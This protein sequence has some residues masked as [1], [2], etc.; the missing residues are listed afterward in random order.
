MIVM[1][2]ALLDRAHVADPAHS[3]RLFED[4]DPAEPDLVARAALTTHV[5]SVPAAS[6]WAQ[7]VRASPAQL[8][9]ATADAAVDTVTTVLALG[10]DLPVGV[11][12]Q[13]DT[14]L[15][16]ARKSPAITN[17]TDVR[18][19]HAI[20]RSRRRR[21]DVASILADTDATDDDPS[22]LAADLA[23]DPTLRTRVLCAI[24][25]R[26][27]LDREP[28][29]KWVAAATAGRLGELQPATESDAR[30]AWTAAILAQPTLRAAWAEWTSSAATTKESDRNS[31]LWADVLAR[32]AAPLNPALQRRIAARIRA[33]ATADDMPDVAVSVREWLVEQ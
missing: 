3:A 4:Y 29:D 6:R 14:A 5:A 8:A 32:V 23:S 27:M 28:L 26:L 25:D 9:R 11:L 2:R 21:A 30:A 18:A 16:A 15:T 22:P 10:R 7:R 17:P 31:N 20:V 12:H 24:G 19:L 33:G 13:L 1:L